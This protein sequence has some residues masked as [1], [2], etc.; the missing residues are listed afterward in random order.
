[1]TKI[2]NE[3]L[4]AAVRTDVAEDAFK[5]AVDN[6]QSRLALDV[7]GDLLPSLMDRIEAI[8]ASLSS[9]TSKAS[10]PIVKPAAKTSKEVK[11]TE[12][13]DA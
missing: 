5:T 6:G 2:Q 3:R 7:L 9:L 13:A 8:E 11:E 4:A 12:Q 1:M 10:E